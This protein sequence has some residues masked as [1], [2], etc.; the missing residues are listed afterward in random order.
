MSTARTTTILVVGYIQFIK[1]RSE[2][3]PMS[4]GYRKEHRIVVCTQ[5]SSS[6]RHSTSITCNPL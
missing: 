1:Q 6:I 5:N 3:N 2:Y 4:I